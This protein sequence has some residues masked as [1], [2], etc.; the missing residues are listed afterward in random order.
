VFVAARK[1]QAGEET[2]AV[3]LEFE[4]SGWVRFKMQIL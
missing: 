1:H 4:K 3:A 2:K